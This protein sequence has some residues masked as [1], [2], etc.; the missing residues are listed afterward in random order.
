MLTP[1]NRHANNANIAMLN[2]QSSVHNTWRPSLPR[3]AHAYHRPKRTQVTRL[4]WARVWPGIHVPVRIHIPPTVPQCP[5]H[6]TAVCVCHVQAHVLL[7][8]RETLS[9]TAMWHETGQRVA[10]WSA[11]YS[12][13]TILFQ[14][15]KWAKCWYTVLWWRRWINN[16]N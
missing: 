12:V 9:Y 10:C 13:V 16:Q 3:A 6:G 5:P 15:A 11:L 7:R 2:M 8:G 1:Y 4:Q 14:Y